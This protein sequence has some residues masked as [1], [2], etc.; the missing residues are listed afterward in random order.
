[1]DEENKST[2]RE[3]VGGEDSSTEQP[4]A[5]YPAGEVGVKS[6]GDEGTHNAESTPPISD[7]DQ[8]KGQTQHPAPD[9]DAGAG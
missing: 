1:M 6:A 7:E 2:P 9:D 8:K 3:K 4:E 5:G